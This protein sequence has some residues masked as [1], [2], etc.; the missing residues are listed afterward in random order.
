[1]IFQIFLIWGQFLFVFYDLGCSIRVLANISKYQKKGEKAL[2][3]EQFWSQILGTLLV[4]TLVIGDVTVDIHS[5][6]I[7]RWEPPGRAHV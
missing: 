3:S 7:K 2:K 6:K 4:L 1:M 5:V